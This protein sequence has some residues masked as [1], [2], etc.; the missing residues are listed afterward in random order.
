VTIWPGVVHGVAVGVRVDV[1]VA[2]GIVVLIASGKSK[3]LLIIRAMAVGIGSLSPAFSA[4]FSAD[5]V[6]VGC[7]IAG[8]AATGGKTAEF[9]WDGS[10]WRIAQ[11]DRTNNRQTTRHK[12]RF[13]F[14]RIMSLIKALSHTTIT[15]ANHWVR[16]SSTGHMPLAIHPACAS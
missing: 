11:L 7:I 16:P 3:T 5:W 10:G 12:G 15:R 6:T 9:D 8:T 1:A 13:L 2:S 14:T 4:S